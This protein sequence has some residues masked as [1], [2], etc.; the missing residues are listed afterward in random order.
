MLRRFSSFLLPALTISAASVS[1]P[2]GGNLQSALNQ[3]VGGDVITLQAGATFTG[4]YALAANSGAIITIQSSGIRNLPAGQR[5]SPSQAGSMARLKTPDANTVLTIPAGANNYVL[6]GLEFVAANGLYGQD[7]IASGTAR[8]TSASQLPQNIVFDRDYV[9]ADPRTGAHRGIALNSGNTA[10]TNSYFSDFISTGQDTQA[11]CG[12]NGTG[13]F[14]IQNNYLQAGTEIVAF[15]G[16][17]PAIPGLIPSNITI[18]NNDFFKPTSWYAGSSDYAGIKVWA[19]NHFELKNAKN[20]TVQNNTFVNNFVQADQLGFVMLLNVRDEGGKVPWA[21]VS[22]VV[23]KNNHFSKTAAGILLM[24]H[25]GDGGGTAGGFTISGNLYDD[26][27][28]G[29]GDGRLYQVMNGVQG[30]TIDHETGFP[31]GWLLIFAQAPSNNV[32]ITNSIFLNGSGIAGEGTS[33][34]NETLNY[35]SPTSTFKNNVVIGGNPTQYSGSHFGTNFFP[36]SPSQVGFVDFYGSNFLLAPNSPYVGTGASI[37]SSNTAPV[38]AI[39]AGWVSIVSKQ[40]GKCLDVPYSSPTNWAQNPGTALQQWD[41]GGGDMQKFRITPVSGGYQI[42]AKVS[43]QS[44]DMQGGVRATAN[45]VLLQQWPWLAAASQTFQINKTSDGYFTLQPLHSLD[46]CIDVATS[47]PTQM[48]QANGAAIQQW[49]CWGGDM[50]K[51]SFV[52]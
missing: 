41:C 39:P 4:H 34:G 25:D 37:G 17:V 19:K 1:V 26:M 46:K 2:A 24:G 47:K 13:P 44:F 14:L 21:T 10:I 51:W 22:N 36:A 45:G 28:W 3:A 11:I 5:V 35:Y 50:Q 49:S 6:Q 18:K 43:G 20:V 52:P 33:P 40:S 15:G 30:I 23:V 31:T 27:A 9:H 42:L 29:G 12:W 38:N 16:A 8:E 7:L 32:N 48:G